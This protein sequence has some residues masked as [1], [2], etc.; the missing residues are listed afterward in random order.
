[1]EKRIGCEAELICVGDGS[2]PATSKASLL[3]R[4]VRFAAKSNTEGSFA[5]SAVCGVLALVSVTLGQQHL[6]PAPWG[7]SLGGPGFFWT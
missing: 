3:I 5:A 6:Y 7:F 2:L 4:V 1:M